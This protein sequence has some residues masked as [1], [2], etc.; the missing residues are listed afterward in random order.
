VGAVQ[1]L[2]TTVIV[3]LVGLATLL[4]VYLANEP[5]RREAEAV[6]QEHVAVERGVQTYIQNCVVCH[7]PAGEGVTEPGARGTGRIGLPLGGST[8]GGIAATELNQSEDP[9]TREERYNIIVNTLQNGRGLMPAFGRGADGGALLN[10]EQIHELA[11]MIQHVDWDHVYN[12]TVAELG[13]YPTPGP[14]PARPAAAEA[15]QAPGGSGGESAESGQGGEGEG[16]GGGQAAPAAFTVTSYDIYFEPGELL[17][18]ANQDVL[19]SLPNLGASPHNFSVDELGIS[20]DQPP[21]A[22][23]LSATINSGPGE[24][25]YYCNVPGH[26]EA[27]MVGT[28]RV[29]EGAPAPEAAAAPAAPAEGGEAPADAGAAPAGDAAAES[30]TVTSFDI[31][32]EPS[33]LTIPADQ[34]VVVALPN[35]GAAPHNFSIDELGVSVD[36][37]A[38]ATDLSATITAAAGSYEYYCNVPG[39]K[40]AGMV[41]TLTVE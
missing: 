25:E 40:E 4:V 12:E 39:H 21:G 26:K 20:V 13:G 3:G 19:V 16:G 29:E 37:P 15:A 30:Y 34:E 14:A 6:E 33:E 38:G 2:A 8:E 36:Q 5:N 23:D 41:G 9:T 17:I 27:G 32:F 22:T 31:Y 24:F 35:Q 7:G 18:P 10:D 28:L 1:K 11:L